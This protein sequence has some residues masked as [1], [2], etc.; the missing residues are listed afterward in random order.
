MKSCAT[1][2]NDKSGK[3]VTIA[4]S[5]Q[6]AASS[7]DMHVGPSWTKVTFPSKLSGDYS[8]CLLVDGPFLISQILP[9]DGSP[10]KSSIL[11]QS[12]SSSDALIRPVAV[13]SLAATEA[14]ISAMRVTAHPQGSVGSK[15][16]FSNSSSNTHARLRCDEIVL[17]IL[18]SGTGQ[19]KW[20]THS[21]ASAETRSDLGGDNG[22]S[23]DATSLLASPMMELS[24]CREA[25]WIPHGAVAAA[26]AC[27]HESQS[28]VLATAHIEGG[29]AMI[30]LYVHTPRVEDVRGSG[31]STAPSPSGRP[32]L[33]GE[34]L[35]TLQ[36]NEKIASMKLLGHAS[37]STLDAEGGYGVLVQTASSLGKGTVYLLTIPAGQMLNPHLNSPSQL[38]HAAETAH[39]FITDNRDEMKHP[40]LVPPVPLLLRHEIR[41]VALSIVVIGILSSLSS[42]LFITDSV[43]RIGQDCKGVLLTLPFTG[44]ASAIGPIEYKEGSALA[45]I[46]LTGGGAV[47][48]S[49]Q[50][51]QAGRGVDLA[52]LLKRLTKSK[53]QPAESSAKVQQ[54]LGREKHDASGAALVSGVATAKRQKMSDAPTPSVGIPLISSQTPAVSS[55]DY[56]QAAI[57]SALYS[58]ALSLRETLSSLQH[59]RAGEMRIL[60]SLRDHLLE[61]VTQG[62]SQKEGSKLDAI[63]STHTLLFPPASAAMEVPQDPLPQSRNMPTGLV[64]DSLQHYPHPCTAQHHPGSPIASSSQPS[65]LTLAVTI[66]VQNGGL[67]P[68]T[69]IKVC[70]YRTRAPSPCGSTHHG[71]SAALASSSDGDG[72]DSCGNGHAGACTMSSLIPLLLPGEG[73]VLHAD[74][75]LT[76]AMSN[77]RAAGEDRPALGSD[78]VIVVVRYKEMHHSASLPHNGLHVGGG[79][80]GGQ[81]DFSHLLRDRNRVAMEARHANTFINSCSMRSSRIAHPAPAG[82]A[83]GRGRR[84]HEAQFLE[85][86]RAVGIIREVTGWCPF[87]LSRQTNQLPISTVSSC[88]HPAPTPS[89][90]V[91]LAAEAL[92]EELKSLATAWRSCRDF[93]APGAHALLAYTNLSAQQ[94][95]S[96]NNSAGKRMNDYAAHYRESQKDTT[97]RIALSANLCCEEANA[98]LVLKRR[99]RSDLAVVYALEAFGRAAD[100][101]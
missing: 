64:I 67:L 95:G 58:Q 33:V 86:G 54:E 63:C 4:V 2:L 49:T 74:I 70:G 1:V 55:P 12:L 85:R 30:R 26:S 42:S 78:A 34:G 3:K 79:E 65:T 68:L 7:M 9:P 13:Y 96:H 101:R 73:A 91:V 31:H 84:S 57:L 27:T 99:I 10:S 82:S 39:S 87:L 51:L 18:D 53:R 41:G 5:K 16:S 60:E 8:T 56:G 97:P 24:A 69:D 29:V 37:Q 25:S 93:A 83:H 48:V 46:G 47:G 94:S 80:G 6:P 50:V 62:G 75:S 61:T 43:P 52:R 28:I 77:R 81:E 23:E 38:S 76:A 72:I 89:S 11:I 88:P 100:E 59:Q 19:R 44:D 90:A 32:V 36:P 40:T 45:Y 21:L 71:S 22:R 98:A 66:T 20:R 14:L 35:L 92:F 15:D 17:E